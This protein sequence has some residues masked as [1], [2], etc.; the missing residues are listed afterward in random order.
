MEEILQL[1]ANM[2][3][4]KLVNLKLFAKSNNFKFFKSFVG[5]KFCGH[6]KSCIFT[7][8]TIFR[9]RSEQFFPQNYFSNKEAKTQTSAFSTITLSNFHFP[10]K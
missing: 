7:V 3:F 9:S 2:N 6:Q 1:L 5:I 8:T 4:L 10:L